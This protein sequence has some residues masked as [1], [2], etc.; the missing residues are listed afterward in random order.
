M[1]SSSRC[2]WSGDSAELIAEAV[3]RPL[4]TLPETATPMAP[5]IMRNM[6]IQL[7]AVAIMMVRYEREKKGDEGDEPRSRVSTHLGVTIIRILKTMPAPNPVRIWKPYRDGGK[8]ADADEGRVIKRPAPINSTAEP[9][10]RKTLGGTL[11][12]TAKMMLPTKEPTGS[13]MVSGRK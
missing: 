11:G 8:E 7:E 4:T 2:T 1:S 6:T 10:K 12:S 9:A 5:P 13:A 3:M